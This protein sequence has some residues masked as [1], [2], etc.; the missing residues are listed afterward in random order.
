M[1]SKSSDQNKKKK[2][3]VVFFNE[4]RN[5]TTIKLIKSSRSEYARD[6]SIQIDQK[7]E[8]NKPDILVEVKIEKEGLIHHVLFI[9]GSNKGKMLTKENRRNKK[10]VVHK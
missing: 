8:H 6:F 4:K 1:W 9:Q 3:W 7:L 10:S 5:N 2:L